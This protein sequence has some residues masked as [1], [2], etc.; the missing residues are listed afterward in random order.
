[1]PKWSKQKLLAQIFENTIIIYYDIASVNRTADPVDIL[2]ASASLWL[3]IAEEWLVLGLTA[4]K[5]RPHELLSR[6]FGSY[7]GVTEQSCRKCVVWDTIGFFTTE[8]GS[9][10]C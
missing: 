8:E 3:R 7:Y 10:L 1:M 9:T 4:S 2:I 5:K 6:D